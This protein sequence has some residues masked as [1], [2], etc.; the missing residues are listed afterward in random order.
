MTAFNTV[1][2]TQTVAAPDSVFEARHF[3][4]G[5]WRDSQTGETFERRNPATG[6]VVTRAA[7]G[8]QADTE[9]AILAAR[10][11]FDSGVW[12]RMSGKDRSIILLKVSQLVEENLEKLAVLEVIES[13]KP[14]SQS[15]D[16]MGG[17]VDLWRYAA[18]LARMVQ[19][20]SH[21]A[22]GPDMMGMVLQEPVGVV[23]VI[24]PWNFPLLIVSQKLPYALAAGCTAVVKP[25]EMTV[26]TTTVLMELLVEAGIPDGVVNMVLGYGDPVGMTMT[27][28]PAVDMVTFTGSTGVGKH[29]AGEAGK[30]LKKVSL[31]LGG[32]NP[33]VIF[34]DGD[35]DA[36]VDASIFGIY[37][38]AG[39][40]CNSSSRVLVHQDIAE[41]FT[42][43]LV[44]LSE[45]VPVGNPLDIST[46]IGAL[47][48]QDHTDKVG[49]YVQSSLKE[50]AK[51]SIG[52]DVLNV[53]GQE[54]F[55][56]QPTILSSV[57]GDMDIAQ[58][59]IFGPVLS[60]ITFKDL[61]DAVS[62]ANNSSYGLS[63]GLWSDNIHT[64]LE[65]TRRVE[66]GTVWVNT[67]MD[68][69]A[70]LPFGGV[71]E[72]GIGRELGRYGLEEFL[73]TKTVQM[74]IGK[75]RANWL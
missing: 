8:N 31:E 41:E 66:A 26:A 16:E 27:N 25:S 21:N 28:H 49:G 68:G 44:K 70:E 15:R 54:G 32:K 63:A 13:G 36:A 11:A 75:T 38:N 1:S 6:L 47:I 74:R 45:Q 51:V 64:C 65:F 20:E 50:G 73:E 53:E 60:V 22:L 29:I 56:F 5:Q 4:N 18:S 12:R 10:Q 46:K 67:W 30:R 14:I 48:S 17:V 19:G 43:K 58:A 34:P 35:V 3:I 62:I 71:K 57:T 72:S 59:E 39:E 33:Q 69:F 7:K 37:F 24:T 52:G 55:F 40:C 9:A 42:Q 23:S 2:G 61:D